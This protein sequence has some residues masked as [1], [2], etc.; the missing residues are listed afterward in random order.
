[1]TLRRRRFPCLGRAG[2]LVALVVVTLVP[3]SASAAGAG[4][5]A[6]AVARHVVRRADLDAIR[7][8]LASYTRAVTDGDRAAFE[9]LLLSTDIPFASV[10]D[11]Q[12][13]GGGPPDTRQ[14]PR[15]RADIFDSGI[16]YSQRFHNVRIEQDGTL[17]NVSLDFVTVDT[18]T[19]RGGYGF[20]VL[21]L[22]KVGGAWK[23][24]SEFFTGRPLSD[25]RR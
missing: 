6:H 11:L 4:L 5:T 2:A 8:L 21:Q 1:M 22:V 19:G 7:R 25:L 3:F 9:A 23:I 24:A 16:R 14:Y 18:A 15:F 13:S 12:E 17:A 10:A 20:K